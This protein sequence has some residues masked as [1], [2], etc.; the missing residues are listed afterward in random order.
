VR[1]L[2]DD[3]IALMH[4]TPNATDYG[5]DF[6]VLDFN[7]FTRDASRCQVLR[8]AMDP[9]F[10]IDRLLYRMD[11]YFVRSKFLQFFVCPQDPD[12]RCSQWQSY[13]YPYVL[14]IV[15]DTATPVSIVMD[16]NRSYTFSH[17][18]QTFVDTWEN[19]N[20]ALV[21]PDMCHPWDS[22]SFPKMPETYMSIWNSTNDATAPFTSMRVY[23]GVRK[24]DP[25]WPHPIHCRRDFFRDDMDATSYETLLALK[26][27]EWDVNCTQTFWNTTKDK[28]YSCYPQCNGSIDDVYCAL[29]DVYA[30]A[31]YPQ[32]LFWGYSV[33]GKEPWGPYDIKGA[34]CQ[35]WTFFPSATDGV[36]INME[37]G[38]PV[39]HKWFNWSHIITHFEYMPDSWDSSNPALVLPPFCV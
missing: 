6:E 34:K 27:Q 11:E 25:K 23:A 12:L 21:P 36:S 28:I 38:L 33:C 26:D 16:N 5:W 4:W 22:V 37:T 24:Y 30:Q 20:I 13:D 1:R 2:T 10:F 19:P 8:L 15:H 14:T 3:G 29:P 31:A 35:L 39:N 9:H 32:G 7:T 18:D 17:V